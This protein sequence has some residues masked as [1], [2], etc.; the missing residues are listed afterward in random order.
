MNT[1]TQNVNSAPKGGLGKKIIMLGVIPVILMAI[2]NLSVSFKTSALFDNTLSTLS[3]NSDTTDMLLSASDKVN[4]NLVNVRNAFAALNAS[5]QKSIL[6]RNHRVVKNSR[7]LRKA[8]V[9]TFPPLQQSISELGKTLNETAM[10]DENSGTGL[11]QA[12]RLRYMTRSATNLPLLFELY[13]E[14]NERS[15]VFLGNRRTDSAANNFIFEEAS[16][17]IVLQKNL[18][19]M[20]TVLDDLLKDVTT[21]ATDH[22]NMFQHNVLD[23]L[24]STKML[25]FVVL[26]AV[27][28]VLLCISI[29]FSIFKISTPLV[30]MVQ[31]MDRLSHGDLDVQI[32]EKQKDEIG[33]MASALLVFKENL[34]D[35]K[36]MSKEREEDRKRLAVQQQEERNELADEFESNVGGV[37]SSVATSSTE[38][39]STAKN[40]NAI[41]TRNQKRASNATN[42]A[43]DATTNVQTVASAAE[44]L[45]NSINEIARQVSESSTM[46][47]QAADQAGSTN[48]TMKELADAASKIGQVINLITDIAEQTNLLALN[49]TIEAARAGDAGKGFAVVASEV[50]N[51]ANQTASATDEI[52]SHIKTIQSTTD[53]AVHA[54]DEVSNMIDHMNEVSSAIAAAVEEQG[55]AT[56]EI[57]TNVESAAKSTQ[58]ASADM[59]E[60][61]QSAERN[62]Q[63][64]MNV[65]SAAEDMSAQSDIL[66][67][68]VDKF[69]AQVR[70]G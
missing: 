57:A 43:N 1:T 28:L 62:G 40:M 13:S 47:A 39:Q 34:L 50:K 8:I 25:N 15:L 16:R 68:E 26:A 12:K 6:Q 5:H 70:T 36:R 55:A 2:L 69:L 38:L 7:E 49:A 65:L 56:Q 66:R 27:G 58:N 41:A 19:H 21:S 4:K 48:E 46:A 42:A 53:N 52:S 24:S 10:F 14:S 63:V 3:D 61:T 29:W 67:T 44:E 20:T 9:A 35:T 51:L 45:S 32:P 54:I 59:A 33:S 11:V 37:V 31:A 17:Q 60:V 30:N 18:D 64:A 23:E 22:R